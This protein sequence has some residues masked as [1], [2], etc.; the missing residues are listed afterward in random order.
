VDLFDG[1][2]VGRLLLVLGLLIAVLGA[3]LVL[4]WRPPLGRLPGDFSG[5]H[6]SFSW[7]LP[8]GTSLLI[9]VIL[10]VVINLVIRR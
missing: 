7:A 3:L 6:G 10:T 2:L 8:L 1:T 5:S 4:G 9:S